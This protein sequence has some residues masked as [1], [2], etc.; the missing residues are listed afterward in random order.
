MHRR[1]VIGLFTY[2][3]STCCTDALPPPLVFAAPNQCYLHNQFSLFDGALAK[4]SV[5]WLD[6]FISLCGL[7][8]MCAD[9][10]VLPRD[11]FVGFAA[12]KST[13]ATMGFSSESHTS[14]RSEIENGKSLGQPS[15]EKLRG[16]IAMGSS[17]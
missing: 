12:G 5:E 3:H 6:A 15:Y 16:D 1:R 11:A 7:Q 17:T 14:E 2:M 4:N 10:R 9:C 8:Y 13:T